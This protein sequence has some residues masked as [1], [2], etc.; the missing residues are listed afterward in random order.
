[1]DLLWYVCFLFQM[2]LLFEMCL[3]LRKSILTVIPQLTFRC[4]LNNRYCNN[5]SPYTCQNSSCGNVLN[6]IDE[7]RGEWCQMEEILYVPVPYQDVHLVKWV[8][9]RNNNF[10]ENLNN[11]LLNFS[12]STKHWLYQKKSRKSDWYIWYNKKKNIRFDC[13]SV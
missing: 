3:S 1:M 6:K 7:I 5:A 4:T 10:H 13:S 9:L 11:L 2:H 8:H 12:I